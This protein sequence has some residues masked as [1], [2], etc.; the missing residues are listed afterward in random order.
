[1][2]WSLV[3]KEFKLFVRNPQELLVLLLMPLIL[4][5]ILGFA[6]GSFFNSETPPITGK[7]AIVQIGDEEAE[8]ESFKKSLAETGVPESAIQQM[9]PSITQLLPVKMLRE[10]VFGNEELKKVITIEEISPSE[11]KEAKEQGEYSAIIEIPEG[12]TEKLLHTLFIGEQA[13]P[14]LVIHENEELDYSAAFTTDIMDQFKK[15]YSVLSALGKE[16]LITGEEVLAK[17]EIEGAVETVTKQDPIDAFSYYAVGMSVMFVLFLSGNISTNSFV[18]RQ[19]H[20]YDRIRLANVP[21]RVYLL[22]VFF[23]G[24]IIALLQLCILYGGAA[25]LYGVHWPNIGLFLL[26]TVLIS[27]VI[28]GIGV[29]LT[30]INNQLGNDSASKLY[31]SAGVAILA[32]LGGSFTKVGETL[33]ALGDLT[34]NGA[35]MSAYLNVMTGAELSDISHYLTTLFIELVILIG[36]ASLI[37]T[38]KA[39]RA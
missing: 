20:V 22:G 23:S 30:A 8:L 31:G 38:R 3:Q 6:L 24:F 15:Q 29:L 13:I 21:N 4:I 28:G 9:E 18:E 34:P 17:I 39:G 25:L 37:S 14:E 19:L 16:G 35:A 33:Q 11:V 2:I 5:T 7:V 32:F 26:I 27:A 36:A 10:K 12:F 1:M